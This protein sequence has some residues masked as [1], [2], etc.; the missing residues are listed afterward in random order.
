MSVLT[1]VNK[2]NRKVSSFIPNMGSKDTIKEH[3]EN[4]QTPQQIVDPVNALKDGLL[5]LDKNK[6]EQLLSELFADD[7]KHI[8]NAE[9][10]RITKKNEQEFSDWLVKKNEDLTADNQERLA[11]KELELEQAIQLFS[12]ANIEIKLTDE[13][14]IIELVFSAVLNII[15]ERIADKNVVLS[16]V[17]QLAKQ[18]IA[19]KEPILEIGSHQ[20]NLIN[21]LGLDKTT[22]A[23]FTLVEKS[24][25]LPGSYC[26]RLGNDSISSDL[27]QKLTAFKQGLVTTYIKH[28]EVNSVS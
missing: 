19:D 15:E 9:Q 16:V 2:G 12:Q 4:R 26:F 27:E 10:E 17:N 7:L 8:V 5:Q 20:F 13:Q 3:V 22:L 21:E 1:S 18:L 23:R 28:N 24:E 11:S 6:R 25:L 14:Q